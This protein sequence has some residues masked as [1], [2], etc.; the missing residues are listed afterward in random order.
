MMIKDNVAVAVRMANE[1]WVAIRYRLTM[2]MTNEDLTV[3]VRI[4]DIEMREGYARRK[5]AAMSGK[6]RTNNHNYRTCMVQGSWRRKKIVMIR[7]RTEQLRD[8]R[9]RS[10]GLGRAAPGF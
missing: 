3:C 4:S 8:K 1:M 2:I 10:V 9:P 7:G 5:Y 6:G